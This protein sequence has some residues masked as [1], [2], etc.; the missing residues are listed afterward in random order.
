MKI[1][2]LRKSAKHYVPSIGY[3]PPASSFSLAKYPDRSIEASADKLLT[4]GWIVYIQHCLNMI[5]VYVDRLS[6]ET[7]VKRVEIR[8]IIGRGEDERL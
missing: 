5:H 4:G 6:E 7:N 1:L 8:V 3:I 2:K